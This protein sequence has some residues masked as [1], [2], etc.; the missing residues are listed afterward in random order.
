VIANGV[1]YAGALDGKL[2]ILDAEG[3][4]G[5]ARHVET[6]RAFQ[7]QQRASR[8][9]AADDRRRGRDRP[10]GDQLVHG[11]PATGMFGQMPATCCL[12]YGLKRGE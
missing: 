2:R 10:S 5:I 1:V 8:A 9:T 11:L 6:N 12:V 7:R 3:R 4:H